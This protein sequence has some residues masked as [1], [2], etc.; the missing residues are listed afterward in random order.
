MMTEADSTLLMDA[1][2]RRLAREL[3]LQQRQPPLR[4]PG[5]EQERFLGEGAFGEV[6]LAINRNSGR[7]VA[8]KFYNR[9]GGLDWSLLTREV[10]KLRH[11]FA[12]RYVVQLF[13]VG[14]DADPPYYV[15]EYMEN[16]S[17]EEKL[18]T[19]P[20]TVPEAVEVFHEI[21]VGLAHAHAKGILHCD[22]K[23]ANILL[24]QDQKPRLADFGQ[25]RLSKEQAPAL[26]TLFYMAPEQADLQAV[27]DARWDVYALG[28][29][30][31]R[32][33]TGQPPYRTEAALNEIM[34]MSRLEERLEGYRCLITESPPAAAHRSVPGVD[35]ALVEII[36]R[37]LAVKARARY[38]N[39]QSVLD[40][41][42]RRQAK[43]ERRPLLVLGTLG[44]A[45]VMLVMAVYA[46]NLYLNTVRSARD[47]LVERTLDVD[48]FAA[49][50]AADSYGRQI[51]KYWG[52][53]EREASEMP[54]RRELLALANGSMSDETVGDELQKWLRR[55]SKYWDE[56][57]P[58]RGAHPLTSEWFVDDC[59]GYVRALYP[60]DEPYINKYF[61]YRDYFHGKGYDLEKDAPCPG[62]ITKP[63][64]SIPFKEQGG[65]GAWTVAFT[66]PIWGPEPT[67]ALASTVASMGS[68]CAHGC[69]LA[70]ADAFAARISV[71]RTKPVG[72]LGMM[73]TLEGIPRVEG[74]RH[75]IGVLLDTRMR[76]VILQHPYLEEV[77]RPLSKDFR[78]FFNQSIA[79]ELA[80]PRNYRDPV[81]EEV[82][83]YA[84]P[85]LAAR[86]TVI[87]PDRPEELRTPGWV[88][89]VQERE[90][91]AVQPLQDLSEQLIFPAV[92]AFVVVVLVVLGLWGGVWLMQSD[93]RGRRL[94]TA[95]RRKLGLHTESAVGSAVSS[96]SSVHLS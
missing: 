54:L 89:V 62:P 17:L 4:L 3:S 72:V 52:I 20:L 5:Y 49:R 18:K 16:G 77:T 45:L 60:P 66:V 11:L 88:I 12:D 40:A 47:K 37:C 71:S 74:T 61:G 9:R 30:L 27:P 22:L 42:K 56:D 38:P 7:K 23:P 2:A 26:G 95:L 33:L 82:P 58:L 1:E 65:T 19:G 75:Q 43:R 8:I 36:D 69:L 14:W 92:Q 93:P 53:L 76:G 46:V 32:M 34:N 21:A 55:R 94:L 63:Y 57:A 64:L 83:A 68:P 15:M 81:G 87:V 44:P 73:W 80:D 96:S 48:R 70:A 25:S 91:T 13:E 78:L 85:W 24:D 28:A 29:I 90:S 79:A 6:W 50:A 59:N 84:G 10:E 67:S 31:Y 51:T 86:S 39:V 35:A 41:L